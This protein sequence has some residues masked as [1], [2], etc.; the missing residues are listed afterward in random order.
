MPRHSPKYDP[1]IR[2]ELDKADW[3]KVLPPVLKYAVWRAKKFGS[4]GTGVMPNT[5]NRNQ[6]G[7]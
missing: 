7:Q 4:T 3:D 2:E 1:S 5:V 6:C